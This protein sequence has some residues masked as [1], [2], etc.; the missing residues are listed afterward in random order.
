ML[1]YS[2]LKKKLEFPGTENRFRL[3]A[4]IDSK[5]S[6]YTLIS[7]ASEEHALFS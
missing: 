5:I 2:Q 1:K 7:G 6:R 3:F 4:V